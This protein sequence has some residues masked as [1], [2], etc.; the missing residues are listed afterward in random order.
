MKKRKSKLLC[1][2]LAL[3]LVL[4]FAATPVSALDSGRREFAQI[5]EQSSEPEQEELQTEQSVSEPEP[6]PESEATGE[7][8]VIE[9]GELLMT[10]P[11]GQQT[12]DGEPATGGSSLALAVSVVYPKGKEL[13]KKGDEITLV[14]SLQNYNDFTGTQA[15][16]DY[17]MEKGI[18]AY[19]LTLTYAGAFDVTGVTSSFTS[20]TTPKLANLSYNENKGGDVDTLICSP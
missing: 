14:F 19:E 18:G 7:P 17:L 1:L 20:S 13:L 2:V 10:I 11:I 12:L 3:M 9:G 16:G 15:M 5:P 4:T 6:E 8:E